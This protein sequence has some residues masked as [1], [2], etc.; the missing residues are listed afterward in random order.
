MGKLGF[1]YGGRLVVTPQAGASRE[2]LSSEDEAR[3]GVRAIAQALIDAR[4]KW[5]AGPV[6]LFVSA[7][8][9]FAILLGHH[10]NALGPIHVY[11]Y[12]KGADTYLQ[13]FQIR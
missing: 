12:D 8:F 3:S 13:A 2:A 4:A 11:E 7:P 10:L 9:A 1:D 5:G 6:H